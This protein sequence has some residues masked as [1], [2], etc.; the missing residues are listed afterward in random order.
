MTFVI[1]YGSYL[2]LKR[3]HLPDLPGGPTIFIGRQP[4]QL[5]VAPVMRLIAMGVQT[6]ARASRG[7][8]KHEYATLQRHLSRVIRNLSGEYG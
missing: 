4:V 5:P 1:L 7:L 6:T 2:A 3:A 8:S